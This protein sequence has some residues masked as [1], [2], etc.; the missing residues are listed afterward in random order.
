MTLMALCMLVDIDRFCLAC[1]EIRTDG[2]AAGL[3]VRLSVGSVLENNFLVFR[4]TRARHT[5]KSLTCYLICLICSRRP[6]NRGIVM[7]DPSGRAVGEFLAKLG[8]VVGDVVSRSD[9]QIH[10]VAEK[11]AQ[12]AGVTPEAGLI[13]AVSAGVAGFAA[14]GVVVSLSRTNAL[15][16]PRRNCWHRRIL[17]VYAR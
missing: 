7:A 5:H 8:N 15:A 3:D 10:A 11:I 1:T 17:L 6:S 9:K 4:F 12:R 14:A 2:W 16:I 13:L